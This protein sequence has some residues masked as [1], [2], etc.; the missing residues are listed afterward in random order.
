MLIKLNFKKI[1][2]VCINYAQNVMHENSRRKYISAKEKSRFLK[3]DARTRNSHGHYIKK[4]LII[5]TK[6]Y[7]KKY[8]IFL[9]ISFPNRKIRLNVKRLKFLFVFLIRIH[10]I[11][12]LL[13]SFLIFS[14]DRF[15]LNLIL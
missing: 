7:T 1:Q 9:S 12:T 10:P 8:L 15:T 14:F 5:K 13:I 6:I 2:K 3:I 4:M 11:I